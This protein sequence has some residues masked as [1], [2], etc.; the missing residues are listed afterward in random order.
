[1]KYNQDVKLEYQSRDVEIDKNM[2]KKIS[3]A[4][5]ILFENSIC[6]SLSKKTSEK[7]KIF[8]SA[9]Y[10][11]SDIAIEYSD[12]GAG[13]LEEEMENIEPIYEMI[14]S[15]NGKFTVNNEKGKEGGISCSFR[16]PTNSSKM[17]AF[18]F[19]I[20]GNMF[21]LPTACIDT[22]LK[23]KNDQLKTIGGKKVI[24]HKNMVISLLD[25]SF[26][27]RSSNGNGSNGDLLSIV[28]SENNK[29]V[30][31]P[32]DDVIG[33]DEILV[34]KF[35]HSIFDTRYV[36]GATVLGDGRVIIILNPTQLLM[37]T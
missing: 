7:G 35:E 21:A 28:I 29:F 33:E 4:L 23:V 32:V 17:D 26:L 14:N 22:I 13:A 11:D 30:A 16:V 19:E 27:I 34:K 15:I 9:N 5:K 1:M 37:E 6:L 12:D 31:V 18:F 8:I 2:W 25:T 24:V 3:D 10:F 36:L 20:N